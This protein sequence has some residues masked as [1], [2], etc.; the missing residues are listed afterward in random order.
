MV[1]MVVV[2]VVVVV[3][4]LVA[5]AFW[6]LRWRGGDEVQSVQG[7]RHTLDTLSDIRTRQGGGSVRVVGSSGAPVAPNQEAPPGAPERA[8]R[9]PAAGRP[10]VFDDAAPVLP[11]YELGRPAGPLR[12]DRAISLMNHRPRRLAGPLLVVLV[13]LAVLGIVVAVGAHSHKSSPKVASSTTTSVAHHGGGT[14]VPPATGHGTHGGGVRPTTT[15][16][17]Q[18]PTVALVSSSSTSATFTVPT[19][20]YTLTLGASSGSCWVSVDTPDNQTLF[21]QTLSGG[22]SQSVQAN[23]EVLIDIGAPSVVQVA[24]N[25]IALSLP[26][27]Y[28]TPFTMTLQPGAPGGA[29][30]TTTTSTST[31]NPGA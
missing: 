8:P 18:A 25:G 23:G 2:A 21:T 12:R 17:T 22:Q 14:T 13:V 31:T 29:S 26:S 10:L 28:Q 7:Y 24:V 15:T 1:L 30:T 27:D 19:G 3:V 16:T 5:G 20:S 11:P 4:L 9:P 6:F